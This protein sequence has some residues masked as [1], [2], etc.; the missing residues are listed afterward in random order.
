MWNYKCGNRGNCQLYDQTK[1]RYYINL[2]A[3]ALTSV[4][5]FFD[6]LIWFYGKNIDLYGEE[7]ARRQKELNKR[8]QPIS[9]LL[10]KRS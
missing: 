7:E 8:N 3:V 10:S 4:G 6:V 5:V 2:T 1:F 9:P